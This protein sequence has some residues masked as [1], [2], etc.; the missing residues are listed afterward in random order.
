MMYFCTWIASASV[1]LNLRAET[2]RRLMAG[3]LFG[4]VF[5]KNRSTGW[6]FDVLLRNTSTPLA[7]YETGYEIMGTADDG[8]Q[9]Q[10]STEPD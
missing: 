8:G 10:I 5:A 3:F 2:R 1:G 9:M 4:P 6:M 7:G